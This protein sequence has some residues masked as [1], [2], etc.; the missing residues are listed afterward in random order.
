MRF[1]LRLAVCKRSDA[2]S[3][4]GSVHQHPLP[5]QLQFVSMK[6]DLPFDVAR[7]AEEVNERF[8]IQ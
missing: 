1:D 8:L 7:A 6:I 2:K 5:T 3:H 4:A